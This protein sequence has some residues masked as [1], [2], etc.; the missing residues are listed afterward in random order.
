MFGS[1]DDRLEFRRTPAGEPHR[2]RRQAILRA[3]PEVV[4][5]F[6]F[7][8]R[9]IGRMAL[10][11]AVQLA[12]AALIAAIASAAPTWV[13]L[14]VLGIVAY[15]VGAVLNH[16]GGV[17]IHEASHNLCAR[18][19]RNN[20]WVAIFANLPKV[21]PYA[22]T[23]R[24]YHLVHHRQL[25]VV[26]RDNDL[27]TRFERRWVRNK[28]IRKLLWL[29]AYPIFGALGRGFL[30]APNRWECIN[31]AVQ[32][33][34][35]ALVLAVLGPWALGYLALS[36]FLSASLHPI[37]GHFIHEHY[38]WDESQETYSYYGPLNAWTENMG[39]HV[40]HHDFMNIPGSRLPELHAIAKEYYEPLVS[41]RSWT[42]IFWTFVT[43]PRLS[44]QSR[45][46]R[47]KEAVRRLDA[48]TMPL[49]AERSA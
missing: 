12:L 47:S 31:I 4:R 20:R 35:N 15:L 45:F 49:S 21:L 39:L 23:F 24:R 13:T 46:V 16:Y 28:P 18:C 17:V 8:R 2:V 14:A 36:T 43:D 29:I 34:F 10:A 30:H 42:K 26:G 25:G 11:L 6:G 41:H 32:L 7:D 44:H 40:E 27:A 1:M 38:L 3:H 48:S 9:P 19:E 5:L 22:M 33:A 37:A